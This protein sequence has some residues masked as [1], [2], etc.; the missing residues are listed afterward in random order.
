MFVS[1]AGDLNAATSIILFTTIHHPLIK[2]GTT[3]EGEIGSVY[4]SLFMVF[5]LCLG[6]FILTWLLGQREIWIHYGTGLASL[7]C[8]L[9]FVLIGSGYLIAFSF[10]GCNV[11]EVSCI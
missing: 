9:W 6:V 10:V 1:A 2:R 3:E 7:C 4:F 8:F 5:L 11:L